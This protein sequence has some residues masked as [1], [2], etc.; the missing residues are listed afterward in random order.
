MQNSN[1]FQ[2]TKIDNSLRLL[3]L[4]DNCILCAI[5]IAVNAIWHS[6]MLLIVRYVLTILRM[7]IH[8]S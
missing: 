2:R 8:K 4:E 1:L 6:G 3:T 5:F 7:L